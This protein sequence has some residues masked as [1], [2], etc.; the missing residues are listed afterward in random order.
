LT[1]QHQRQPTPSQVARHRRLSRSPKPYRV[2]F[3][4]R[5]RALTN[6]LMASSTVC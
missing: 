3:L 1:V 4:P 6:R 5:G 2:G